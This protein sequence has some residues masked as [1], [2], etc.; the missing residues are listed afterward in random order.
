MAG[1]WKHPD[2]GIYWYRK[3]LP[4]D[5]KKRRDELTA[6]GI[7]ATNEVQRS[8]HTKSEREAQRRYRE[9]EEKIAATH[10][11]WRGI[12]G[13]E[14]MALSHRDIV[15]VAGHV[16]IDLVRQ[17]DE[18]PGEFPTA[19]M[20]QI[21]FVLAMAAAIIGKP[22]IYMGD[23]LADLEAEI[24]SIPYPALRPHLTERL[25]KA[26][27]WLEGAITGALIV[28]DSHEAAIAR[29]RLDDLLVRKGIRPDRAAREEIEAK[30]ARYTDEAV[31]TLE[32][33]ID[34]DYGQ[35]AWFARVPPLPDNGGDPKRRK[36]SDITFEAIISAR[37]RRADS[38]LK[39]PAPATARKYR[40]VS[41]EF[42]AWRHG[43]ASAETLTAEE[44]AAWRDTLLQRGALPRTVRHKVA[45]I[46]TIYGWGHSLPGPDALPDGK[47]LATVELP[48]FQPPESGERTFTE[49]EAATI[50]R[51]ARREEKPFLRWVSW[52]M[53][54]SGARIGEVLQLTKEDLEEAGDEEW[55]FHV[56]HN[57]RTR[58]TKT[59]RARE[60]PIHPALI[61]E[62]LVGFVRAS[63]DGPLFRDKSMQQ[64]HGEWVRGLF[65]MGLSKPPAHGFRHLFEDWLR[66]APVGDDFR[67][68]VTGRGIPSSSV[69]YGRGNNYKHIA[70]R[71][72][73]KVPRYRV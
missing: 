21:E 66:G 4:S 34:G 30:L 3:A 55:L 26:G 70:V 31:R 27:P 33:R 61:D 53:A 67:M 46:K 69:E 8:L 42:V 20:A 64:R 39:H 28:M 45:A 32:R 48:V 17:Y 57:G 41:R 58:T 16:G 49:E 15:A 1:P 2:S 73:A 59:R 25:S 54:Y 47:R 13:R 36:P 6:A 19:P 65:G 62:G 40:Q 68:Y 5:L 24:Q 52:I 12:L 71:E 14:P 35:P 37:E 51:A 72:M 29:S 22:A 44:L 18:N 10:D 63:D 50:L 60:I 43:D 11:L 23:P 7:E 38:A 9:L 56:R